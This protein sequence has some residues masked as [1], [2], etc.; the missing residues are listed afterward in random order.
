MEELKL[1][2]QAHYDAWLHLLIIG[3]LI[4]LD[5]AV[6]K[7]KHQHAEGVYEEGYRVDVV[8]KPSLQEHKEGIDRDQCVVEDAVWLADGAFILDVELTDHQ[9]HQSDDDLQVEPN[10]FQQRILIL[11]FNLV[12]LEV[13]R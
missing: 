7:Q 8:M 6:L 12:F 11:H 10:I 13:H 1:D 4:F 2:D 9:E 3:L 5:D